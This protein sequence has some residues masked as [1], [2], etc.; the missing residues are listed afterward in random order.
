M[1]NI[2]GNIPSIQDI[3]NIQERKSTW[4]EPIQ[5][6]QLSQ[7]RRGDDFWCVEIPDIGYTN[8]IGFVEIFLKRKKVITSLISKSKSLQT[9]NFVILIVWTSRAQITL[10]FLS[11]SQLVA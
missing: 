6:V 2:N 9:S 11:R 5:I 8:S 1:K 10:D 7:K 4:D 3:R